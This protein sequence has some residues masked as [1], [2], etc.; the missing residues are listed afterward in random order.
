MNGMKTLHLSAETV[1]ALLMVCI[2]VDEI[3][4]RGE[5]TADIYEELET[6]RPHLEQFY[7]AG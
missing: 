3:L 5:V 2:D 1:A 7:A 4:E 6:L